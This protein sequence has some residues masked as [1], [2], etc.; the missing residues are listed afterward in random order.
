MPFR[1]AIILSLILLLVGCSSPRD[2][3]PE[4]Q[5]ARFIDDTEKNRRARDLDK[6]V[7]ANVTS[8]GI[9]SL[10]YASARSIDFEQQTRQFA[11]RMGVA[12]VGSISTA[13]FSPDFFIFFEVSSEPTRGST[14]THRELTLVA[15]LV[16]TV[17]E[18]QGQK[19]V[20]VSKQTGRCA[21]K[22]PNR[23]LFTC[24]E[25]PEMMAEAALYSFAHP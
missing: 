21:I 23:V 14:R 10:G 24:D 2:L 25:L 4:Q 18:E 15:N 13:Q 9:R 11:S 16:R 3:P 8:V 12:Y 1:T 5:P 17:A 6:F 20:A 7:R 22:G 19:V